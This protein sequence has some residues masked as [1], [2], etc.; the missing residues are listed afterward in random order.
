MALR[1]RE[2]VSRGTLPHVRVSNAIRIGADDLAAFVANH[3]NGVL[4]SGKA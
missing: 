3:R 4:Y 1:A 2:H